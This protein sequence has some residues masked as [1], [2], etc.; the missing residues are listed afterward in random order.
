MEQVI[1]IIMAVMDALREVHQSGLIHRD[2]S[3]DNIYITKKGNVKLLDFGAARIAF[4]EMS[5]SLSVILKPGFAPEEQYR[6]R[7]QQGPWTDIYGVG[8]TLYRLITGV[9]PLESL[10]RYDSDDMPWPSAL[11]IKISDHQEAALKKAM[12][13]RGKDRFQ[14]VYEFQMALLNNGQEKIKDSGE[15]QGRSAEQQVQ[16][17]APYQGQQQAQEQESYQGQQQAQVQVPYQGQQQAQVQASYQG[18]QQSQVQVPYQGQQQAQGQTPYEGNKDWI[19]D[20]NINGYNVE[21]FHPDNGHSSTGR[22]FKE[23][24]LGQSP[25]RRKGILITAA[26]FSVLTLLIV[27]AIF[28]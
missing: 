23:V 28:A 18:Q 17:Q 21:S 5:K 13:F 22:A 12:A 26:L 3:P 9:T 27:I 2:I 11:G 16:G 10:E 6:T 8:A 15:S 19:S 14:T 7:G 24:P 4:G 20:N 1:Q 25:N